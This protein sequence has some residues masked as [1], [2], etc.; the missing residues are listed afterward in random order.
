[1]VKRSFSLA[2]SQKMRDGLEDVAT[3]APN[4][5]DNTNLTASN[6]TIGIAD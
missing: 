2:L 5:D 1:M 6:L 3:S 4:K